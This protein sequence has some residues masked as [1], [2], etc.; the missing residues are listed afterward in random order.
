MDTHDPADRLSRLRMW[1]TTFER[2]HDGQE[3]AELTELDLLKYCR[4]TLER[5][6]GR[7]A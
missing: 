7:R 1:W 3:A 4:S 5:R 6:P 2:A